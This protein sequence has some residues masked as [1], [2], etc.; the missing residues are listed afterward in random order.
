MASASCAASSL[1]TS[2]STRS[3]PQRYDLTRL[4]SS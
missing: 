2:S 3:V 1:A 4:T